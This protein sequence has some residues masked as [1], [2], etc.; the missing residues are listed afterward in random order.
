M[1]AVGGLA[2]LAAV[3]GASIFAN[4]PLVAV[5]LAFAVGA[6]GVNAVQRLPASAAGLMFG[7]FAMLL[8]VGLTLL[9]DNHGPAVLAGLLLAALMHRRESRTAGLRLPAGHPPG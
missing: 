6:V 5:L 2:A 3:A 8:G 7:S 1:I 4:G 9:R